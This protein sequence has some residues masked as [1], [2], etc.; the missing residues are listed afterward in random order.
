MPLSQLLPLVDILQHA[1]K[2]QLMQILL[3]QLAA[4][5]Q[6]DLSTS[7]PSVGTKPTGSIRDNPGFG[8]WSDVGGD[9]RAYLQ[10]I[11]Q[12]QWTR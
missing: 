11:R 3:N 9:S 12:R 7:P 2:F 5:E 8:M 6:I 10:Q 1:E 4:E